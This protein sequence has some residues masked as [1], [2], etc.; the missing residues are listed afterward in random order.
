MT[1]EGKIKR[2]MKTP[3]RIYKKRLLEFG[4]CL[5]TTQSFPKEDI[6]RIVSKWCFLKNNTTR[7]QR[8]SL[9]IEYALLKA[10]S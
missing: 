4:L 3:P 2:R 8:R 5:F 1:Q 7:I 6:Y 10:F 9:E